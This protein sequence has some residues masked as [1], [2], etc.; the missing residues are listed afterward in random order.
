MKTSIREKILSKLNKK[1]QEIYSFNEIFKISGSSDKNAIRVIISRIV[2]EKRLAPLKHG[3]YLYVPEGYEKNWTTNNF[4]IGANLVEPYA[5]SFW[6]ALNHWGFTEQLPNKTY[7]QTTK[8]LKSRNKVILNNNYQF[9]KFTRKRFFG[10]T[11]IWVANHQVSITDKEKT[12]VDCLVY[13]QYSGGIIEVIKGIYQFYQD[14]QPENIVFYAQKM[15]QPALK[16]LGFILELL[17][18]SNQKELNKIKK[19]INNPNYI[20]LE[21]LIK[22]KDSIKNSK[23]KVKINIAR[24]DL[25]EWKIT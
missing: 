23:W 20:L 8:N 4:W 22:N 5:I 10:I 12:L 17:G 24:K 15:G 7:I 25:L 3:I 21:P 11:K 16:R 6:S 19:L 18:V 9:V 13:P 1:R 14:K 2:K